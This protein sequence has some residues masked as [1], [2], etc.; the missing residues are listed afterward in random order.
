[1]KL[2]CISNRRVSNILELVDFTSFLTF[3]SSRIIIVTVTKSIIVYK[4]I[5][6]T[7]QSYLLLAS[8]SDHNWPITRPNIDG[9]SVF[10]HGRVSR[11]G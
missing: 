10:K 2:N 3:F 7:K 9:R 8:S 1:M 11:K 4:L 6:L 5:P